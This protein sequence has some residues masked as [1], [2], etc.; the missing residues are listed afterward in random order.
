M[1]A[2]WLGSRK[3]VVLTLVM[4]V[5]ANVLVLSRTAHPAEKIAHIRVIAVPDCGRLPLNMRTES[6]R[7]S[8]QRTCLWRN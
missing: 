5:V 8:D 7:E 1:S 2:C 6:C 3:S 4:L